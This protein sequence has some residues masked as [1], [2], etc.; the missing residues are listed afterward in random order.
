[1]S[2]TSYQTAPPRGGKTMLSAVRGR[3]R[4][5]RRSGRVGRRVLV[6]ALLGRGRVA[7]EL[8]VGVERAGVLV[9]HFGVVWRVGGLGVAQ[10]GLAVA[11]AVGAFVTHHAADPTPVARVLITRRLPFPALERLRAAGHELEVWPGEL[12]PEPR[13]LRNLAGDKDALL[14]LLTDRID[15]ELLEAAP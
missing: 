1:M 8:D 4:G 5:P 13:E 2:P 14:C 15:D 9:D 3:S 7:L 11:D 10:G 12:P 6:V